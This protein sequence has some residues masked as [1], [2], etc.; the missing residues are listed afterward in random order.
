[1]ED[2]LAAQS[3]VGAAPP[4]A[5]PFGGPLLERAKLCG[6]GFGCRSALQ[7]CGITFDLSTTHFYQGVAGG[8]L[9][10]SFL[11][12]GRNDYFLNVDG[13]QLGLWKG[14][15]FDLHGETRF[16]KSA[17]FSTGALSPVNEM[18]L[19]PTDSGCVTALTGVRFTQHL[20]DNV[21]IYAGKIN[22]LDDVRQ[23][24]TGATP[25]NGFLNTSLIFNTIFARTLPYSTLGA[26]FVVLQDE[27]PILSLSVYDPNDTPTTSGFENFFDG[28]TVF[29]TVN[30]PTRFFGLPGHQGLSG[31]Y[32]TGR[33]TNLSPSSYLDPVDDLAFA[34][35]PKTRSWALAYNFDQAVWAS[36]DD[37]TK[38]WGVF[39][40]LGI[41]D[42]NPNPVR[43]YASVGVAGANPVR[44]QDTFGVGVF[45]LGISD[46]LK[47]SA[48][49]VSPLRNESGAELYYNARVTPWFQ[50]TPDLQ[51]I[52]PFEK[53]ADTAVVLGVRAKIDF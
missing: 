46:E 16:G 36:S 21:L 51:F 48:R 43:W 14:G 12:G 44:P 29:G 30:V 24:L 18:L 47:R 31:T 7:E 49:P 39:G 25:L 4:P 34:S 6:D 28:A 13:E 41:A 5:P 22:T 26:G 53:N 8:G 35:A 50:I 23:P 10:R 1:M 32:S 20:S 37:P 40:N 42:D 3:G 15:S 52:R 11:Y 9:E 33:Y 45:Y 2:T 17:N 19:V 27:E 38:V